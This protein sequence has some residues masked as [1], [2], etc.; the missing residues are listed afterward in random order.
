MQGKNLIQFMMLI[1]A[2]WLADIAQSHNAY[3]V[4]YL[5]LYQLICLN[6]R[7]ST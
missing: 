1:E 4:F 2:L 7:T 3:K 5:H 6:A